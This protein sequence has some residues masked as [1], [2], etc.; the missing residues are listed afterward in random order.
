[1][2]IHSLAAWQPW[3]GASSDAVNDSM[4]PETKRQASAVDVTEVGVVVERRSEVRWDGTRGWRK[5]EERAMLAANEPQHSSCQPNYARA[6][7]AS[8]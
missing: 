3:E 5:R 6:H 2:V 8:S 4:L 7:I 1:M